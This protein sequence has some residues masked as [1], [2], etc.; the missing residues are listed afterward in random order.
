MT[1]CANG[2]LPWRKIREVLAKCHKL[3]E[4]IAKNGGVAT[5]WQAKKLKAFEQ[6]YLQLIAGARRRREGIGGTG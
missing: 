4:A 1:R 3:N 2:E 6:E 5:E